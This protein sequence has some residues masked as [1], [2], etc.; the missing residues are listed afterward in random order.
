GLV[1]FAVSY[2]NAP[3][4]VYGTHA[5]LCFSRAGIA[6]LGTIE[7]FYDARKRNFAALDENRPYDFRVFPC[8]FVAYI[9]VQVPGTW[10]RFGP[11]DRLPDDDKRQFWVPLHKLFNGKECLRGLDLN[12]AFERGLRNDE[13]AMFRRFLD[14]QGLENNVRGPEL[15]DYP[16]TIKDEKIGSLSGLDAFGAGVLVPLPQPVSSVAKYQGKDLA[17]PV[18]GSYSSKNVELASLQVLPSGT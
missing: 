18:D 15:E 11:Q 8:R 12:V 17:F 2:R 10:S 1:A 9:A 7:P 13:L 4:S 6:R 16:F 5:Q 3:D 14:T